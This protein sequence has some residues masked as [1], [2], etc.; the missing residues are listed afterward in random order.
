[1]TDKRYEELLNLSHEERMKVADREHDTVKKDDPAKVMAME[2]H[3][4]A[5]TLSLAVKAVKCYDMVPD[6]KARSYLASLLLLKASVA[7]A[8]AMGLE[9]QVLEAFEDFKKELTR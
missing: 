9:R 7:I 2:I 5:S 6:E 8:K 1:M 3:T 4:Q